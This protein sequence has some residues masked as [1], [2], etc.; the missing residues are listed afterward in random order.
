MMMAALLAASGLPGEIAAVRPAAW[1]ELDKDLQ[2]FA[3]FSDLAVRCGN[4]G[5]RYYV[6]YV[7]DAP[8]GTLPAEWGK[9]WVL[10][11]EPGLVARVSQAAAQ[12]M[13]DPNIDAH[14]AFSQ[15]RQR[16]T[17]EGWYVLEQIGK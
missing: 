11:P 15:I 4:D 14:S 7:K 12:V 10:A 2:S 8:A 9:S 1:G 17:D 3:Q 16:S 13:A 6:P 5:S